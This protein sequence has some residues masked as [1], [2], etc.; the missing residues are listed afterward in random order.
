MRFSCDHKKAA[1]GA[2]LLGTA[3]QLRSMARTAW[4]RTATP[5]DRRE[6]GKWARRVLVIYGL[7]A[8]AGMSFAVVLQNQSPRNAAA[9]HAPAGAATLAKR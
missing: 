5:A 6:Y 2:S 7:L 1:S 4:F 8:L 3:G 9:A